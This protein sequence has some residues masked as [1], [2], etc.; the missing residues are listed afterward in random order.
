MRRVLAVVLTE[1]LHVLRDRVALLMLAAV[2][3]LFTLVLSAAFGGAGMGALRVGLVPGAPSLTGEFERLLRQERGLSVTVLPFGEAQA[4]IRRGSLDAALVV[5]AEG[6]AD[7]GVRVLADPGSAAGYEAYTRLVALQAAA[8]GRA[9]AVALAMDVGLDAHAAAEAGRRYAAASLPAVQVHRTWQPV[10]EG[11][12]QVSPGML[13]MF[14]LMFAAYSGEG[15]VLERMNGTLRR[16]QA[17]PVGA[18]QYLAGRLLGKLSLGM[19][20]FA[21]LAL[22]GALVLKVN[23]GNAPGRMLFTGLLFTF[24]CAA[25]G[26]LLGVVCRSPDQLS[27]VAT[28]VCLALAALGGTWWPLDV[29][30]A[31]LQALGRLLPTGQAMTAFHALILHGDGGLREAGRAWIGMSLW[32]VAFLL[33][34][35]GLFRVGLERRA[36][37]G[38]APGGSLTQ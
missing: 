13:V 23:W 17:A 19:L 35:A 36:C 24:T 9:T 25:F 1:W 32:G 14:L 5:P 27:A 18:W 20:Q 37:H 16:L 15:I 21:L 10:A 28:T 31:P 26:L 33:A 6:G 30:P 4:R 3:V 2:P 34:G 38:G 29:A 12:A 7:T 22:F 11:A 8:S